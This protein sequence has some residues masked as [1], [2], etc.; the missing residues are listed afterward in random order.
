MNKT[1]A[2]AEYNKRADTV[3]NAK[4]L[5]LF[6]GMKSF[7]PEK[8][9]EAFSLLSDR[10]LNLKDV[11]LLILILDLVEA[12]T[13]PAMLIRD[14]GTSSPFNWPVRNPVQPYRQTYDNGT[15]MCRAPEGAH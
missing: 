5:D 4:E 2:L 13:P 9:S 8:I 11:K 3:L 7:P 10:K 6:E 15:I 12:L 14:P 1:I